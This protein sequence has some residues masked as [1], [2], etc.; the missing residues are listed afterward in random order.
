VPN[1]PTPHF[2]ERMLQLD[3]ATRRWLI[4]RGIDPESVIA[5]IPNEQLDRMSREELLDW[6]RRF[7]PE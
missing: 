6:Y 2:K 7:D 4:E 5:I 1:A 3:D